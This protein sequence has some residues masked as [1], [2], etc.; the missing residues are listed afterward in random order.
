MRK[1]I[2]HHG[3]RIAKDFLPETFGR[4]TTIGPK[5]MLHRGPKQG[6]PH[7]VCEC[8][9][10]EVAV[11]N[12]DHLRVGHTR[13][14]GCLDLETKTRLKTSHGMHKDPH[15]KVYRGMIARC[16]DMKHK[17]YADYGGRGIYVEAPWLGD[18]G[19]ETWYAEMGPR[20]KGYTIERKDNDGPYS[21]DNCIWAS[22]EAQANNTSKNVMLEIDGK[23]D[24]M[25]NWA[26]AFG[27]EYSTFRSRIVN[28]GWTAQEAA[29][30]PIGAKGQ[31]RLTC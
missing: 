7:Q 26:R 4:L 12:V 25:S 17:Q 9:C 1:Y 21:K 3:I 10:G 28:Y 19:F 13:S 24:T 27:V 23:M 16:Y 6:R 2:L 18:T 20:P 15:Y 29:Y 14:C 31:R 5:F 22:R 11:V 8:C 30:T